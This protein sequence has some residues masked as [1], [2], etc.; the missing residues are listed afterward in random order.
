MVQPLAETSFTLHEYAKYLSKHPVTIRRW[1]D[2]D[3]EVIRT[4][5]GGQRAQI[6]IPIP[7]VISF[8]REIG[9]PQTQVDAM[10]ADHYLKFKESQQSAP[11][12]AVAPAKR[13]NGHKPVKKK[14]RAARA[15]R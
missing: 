9:I 10:V 14:A 11:A 5:R 13:T 7:R 12:P 2:G 4:P 3:T 8:S 15:G 1:F 6:L